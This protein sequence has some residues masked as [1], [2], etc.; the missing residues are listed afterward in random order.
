MLTQTIRIGGTTTPTT[1][2]NQTFTYDGVNRLWTSTEP[3]NWSQEY[4]YDQYGNRWVGAGYILPQNVGLTPQTQ[5]SFTSA[6]N[7]LAVSGYDIS[8]NQT[9]D[10]Q[11]RQFTYDAENR[12]LTFN[13]T[14]GTYSYDGNGRRVRKTD[15]TGTIVFVY[16]AAGL[17]VAEYTTVPAQPN[18]TSYLITDHLGSTRLVTDISGNVKARHDYLPFGEEIPSAVGRSLVT[19]YASN[20]ST[21]QRFTQKERDTESQLDYFLARYYSSAQG[22]FTSPDEFSG[23]PDELY[24]FAQDASENP[25]FYS[26]PYVPQS[27]N[28]YQYCYNNPLRY[29]DADGHQLERDR[30]GNPTRPVPPGTAP[31]E[32]ARFLAEKTH[33][34][35]MTVGD[36]EIFVLTK[37]RD[38]IGSSSVSLNPYGLYPLQ[39]THRTETPDS[40]EDKD[41]KNASTAREIARSE[42]EKLDKRPDPKPAPKPKATP[43]PKKERSVEGASEQQKGIEEKRDLEVKKAKEA[44]L[45]QAAIESTKK[46]SR[47]NPK[48]ELRK[49]RDRYNKKD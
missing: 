2:F 6:T 40:Q 18:G 5:S 25:T 41:K 3:G 8:G 36:A 17:L 39:V 49:Y 14:A 30:N 16:N 32:V 19:G 21:R 29:V 46:S 23:G 13:T 7:R 34:A 1:S 42:D 4:S 45:P 28:K 37:I 35:L 38:S 48:N 12:Q 33:E 9:Q 43:K 31:P 15:A 24:Y 47:Q 11:G 27:L 22:R 20:D 44:G 26:D 10:G